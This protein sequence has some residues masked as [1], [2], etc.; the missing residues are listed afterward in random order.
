MHAIW[1]ANHSSI[2]LQF[3][4]HRDK[5]WSIVCN[6]SGREWTIK[7]PAFEIDGRS[8]RIELMDI[9]ESQSPR[10]LHNHTT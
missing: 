9:A 8:I 5:F 1:T 2:T 7:A 6:A 10:R 4:G 3:Y